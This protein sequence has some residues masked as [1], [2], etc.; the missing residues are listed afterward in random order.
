MRLAFEGV[1]PVGEEGREAQ[2]GV[3]RYSLIFISE[4][5]QGEP[6]DQAEVALSGAIG[7]LVWMTGVFGYMRHCTRFIT[8]YLFAM[9]PFCHSVHSLFHLPI[10]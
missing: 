9:S 4:R 8:V 3:D 1:W 7:I 10:T 2:Y 6:G 5:E